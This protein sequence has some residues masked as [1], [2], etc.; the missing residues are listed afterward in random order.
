MT[1]HRQVD[2]LIEAVTVDCY[3]DADRAT[4][5][6]TAFSEEVRLPVVASLLGTTVGVTE[7]DIGEDGVSLVAR[8]VNGEIE[9]WIAFADLEFPASTV[10]AWLH[11]AYRRE[12]GLTP[13]PFAMPVDWKRDW[14]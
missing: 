3:N 12:R 6:Y 10:A 7:V 9:R 4:A 13:Y 8:C 2:E 14:L 11:A 5:F 1:D